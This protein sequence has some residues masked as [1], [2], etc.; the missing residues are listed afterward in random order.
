[1]D[2]GS[3]SSKSSSIWPHLDQKQWPRLRST[4]DDCN[5]DCRLQRCS[6]AQPQPPDGK[7]GNRPTPPIEEWET[8]AHNPRDNCSTSKSGH[9][10][11][12]SSGWTF[13]PVT[14]WAPK[15]TG[16]M[17]GL[18]VARFQIPL[19]D[20]APPGQSLPA[21]LCWHPVLGQSIPGF[22]T[23]ARWSAWYRCVQSGWQLR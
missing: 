23:G 2:L 19:F 12:P 3:N 10:G 7:L 6:A 11:R 4:S 8:T 9:C 20:Q 22:W 13:S 16:G 14:R 15:D 5:C 21:G 1:M 18:A 17:R